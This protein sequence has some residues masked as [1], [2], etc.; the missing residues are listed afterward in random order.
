VGNLTIVWVYRYALLT[1]TGGQATGYMS[2]APEITGKEK[3][4]WDSKRLYINY[5]GQ[6]LGPKKIIH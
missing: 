2:I 5:A 3:K 6:Y 1:H 4:L